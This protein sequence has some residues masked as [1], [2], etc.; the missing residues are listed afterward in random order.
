M[1]TLIGHTTPFSGVTGISIGISKYIYTL[2]RE[3]IKLGQNVELFVRDDYKPKEKW[4]KTIYSPKFSWILYPLF[5]KRKIGKLD[6][7]IYHADYVT[8]G[9]PLI[10]KKKSP[11]VVTIHDVIPFTYKKLGMMDR[12]RVWW[13]MRCFK[14]IEKADAVIVMSNF[15]KQEAL[16]Y[17]NILEEKIHVTYNGIDFD[18]FY[19]RKLKT[20]KNIRIGYLG[21]LDGR[22]NVELLVDC[23]EELEKTHKDIELHI[24]GTGKNLERFRKRKI[25]NAF[26]HGFIP[27]ER[28]NEFYNSLDI[29]VFP[30]LQEGFG[31]MP[32]EAMACGIPVI[33]CNRSSMPEVV[34]DAGILVEPNK[35]DMIEE[36]TKLIKD[37]NLRKKLGRKG[38]KRAKQFT[39]ENCARN[40]LKIYEEIKC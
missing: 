7:D 32:L 25:K 26:F 28:V 24:G 30:S 22:K 38:L 3:L 12:I 37:E 5:V 6:S 15:V 17:T 19:P 9:A 11:V 8:T 33:A 40:T 10:W 35:K 34:G 14:A 2:G 31:F 18:K 16:K 27:D 13:Y 4:I 36:I 20:H 23:F 1:I 21:G 39:W 29:F